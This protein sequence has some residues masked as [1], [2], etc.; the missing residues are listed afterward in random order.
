M[1]VHNGVSV[2]GNG[3]GG[4]VVA[5]GAEIE[6]HRAESS[7]NGGVGVSVS[8]VSSELEEPASRVKMEVCN[9]I[10][11]RRQGCHVGEG[12]VLEL[13]EVRIDGNDGIG[14][15][16]EGGGNPDTSVTLDSCE[17]KGNGMAGLLIDQ[18]SGTIRNQSEVQGNQSSGIHPNA[19]IR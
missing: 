11:N 7:S 3:A 10:R 15:H 19:H 18:G 17:I 14:C 9:L 6:L 16:V 1:L 4:I 8:G 13:T 12:G 5:Q 2:K